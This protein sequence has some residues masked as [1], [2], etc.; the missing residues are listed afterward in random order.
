MS[1]AALTRPA[2][3][4]VAERFDR[5]DGRLSTADYNF[6][7]FRAEHLLADAKATWEGRG[8]PPGEHAPD[9]DLPLVGGS[10]IRLADLRG[11]PVLLHFGSFT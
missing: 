10:S 6:K 7:H 5:L 9:F 2:G 8:I 3:D 11:K 1:T 4:E